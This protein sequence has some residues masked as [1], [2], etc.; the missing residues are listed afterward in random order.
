[1]SILFQIFFS[2][3]V[4]AREQLGLPLLTFVRAVCSHINVSVNI[5]QSAARINVK[6]LKKTESRKLS[7]IPPG[8]PRFSF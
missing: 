1:M 4:G 3:R 7:F 8:L 2:V 5:C 6:I